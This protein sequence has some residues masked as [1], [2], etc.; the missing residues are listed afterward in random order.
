V[1]V[2]LL[3]ESHAIVEENVM[4]KLQQHMIAVMQ[5][6]AKIQFRKHCSTPGIILVWPSVH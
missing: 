1:M 2:N 5:G 6:E 4:N 3:K